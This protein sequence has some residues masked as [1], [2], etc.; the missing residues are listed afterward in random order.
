MTVQVE[1]RGMHHHHFRNGEW[2][3]IQ[4]VE[5]A[6]N[7]RPCYFVRFPDN[8]YDLWP[9]EDPSNTYEFRKKEAA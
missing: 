3:T 2:A 7:G 4:G 5:C 9:I 6:P 1:M 8:V